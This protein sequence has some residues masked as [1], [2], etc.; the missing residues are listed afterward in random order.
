M[1]HFLETSTGGNDETRY[2]LY[3]TFKKHLDWGMPS[4]GRVSDRVLYRWSGLVDDYKRWALLRRVVWCADLGQRAS[5]LQW[6]LAA[7][8]QKADGNRWFDYMRSP[9]GE[10][11]VCPR[12]GIGYEAVPE[13]QRRTRATP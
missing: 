12:P 9:D 10:L 6:M 2:R 11:W 1:P 4:S 5:I 3:G 8:S 7:D 13:N